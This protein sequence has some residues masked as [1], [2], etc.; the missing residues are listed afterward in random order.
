MFA[1]GRESE[2]FVFLEQPRGTIFTCP[3]ETLART[4]FKGI[5]G[6]SIYR[7]K[8]DLSVAYLIDGDGPVEI[9]PTEEQ[10]HLLWSGFVYK[11]LLE[12][13]P[14]PEEVRCENVC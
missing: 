4:Y 2:S 8:V 12:W 13:A 6:W 7:L 5:K 9:E 14:Y 3:N 11:S 10:K 1:F